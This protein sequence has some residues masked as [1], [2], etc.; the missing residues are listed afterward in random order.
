MLKRKQQ[1]EDDPFSIMGIMR[2]KDS[3][4]PYKKPILKQAVPPN[5]NTRGVMLEL[6]A[7]E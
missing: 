2:M 4:L 6:E 1:G 3:S 7:R 5:V